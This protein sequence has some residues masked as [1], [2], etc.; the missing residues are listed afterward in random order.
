[1]ECLSVLLVISWLLKTNPNSVTWHSSKGVKESHDEIV[2][3]L[4]KDVDGLNSSSITT[5]SSYFLM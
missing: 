5:N 2:L 3:A 1:M 4:S